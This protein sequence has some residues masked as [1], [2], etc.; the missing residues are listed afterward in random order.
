MLAIATS[1]HGE[2]RARSGARGKRRDAAA[3]GREACPQRS[4]KMHAECPGA[5]ARVRTE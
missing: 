5:Q 2:G 4:T 1:L 3:H